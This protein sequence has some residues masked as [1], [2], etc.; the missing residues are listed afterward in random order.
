MKK[1]ILQEKRE[2]YKE[3]TKLKELGDNEKLNFEQFFKIRKEEEKYYNK[4]KFLDKY[5]KAKEKI[6]NEKN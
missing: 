3:W 1:T 6:D 5:T 2:L 4:W